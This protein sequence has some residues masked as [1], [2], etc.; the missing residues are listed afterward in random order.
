M[1]RKLVGRTPLV[2]PIAKGARD[3][4]CRQQNRRTVRRLQTQSAMAARVAEAIDQFFRGAVDG[5]ALRARIEQE[6]AR[7]AANH[8]AL[9]D[10]TLPEPGLYDEGV[11]IAQA[12]AVSKNRVMAELLYLIVRQVDPRAVIELGTNVA[13]AVDWASASDAT[14][15]QGG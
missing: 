14:P 5:D 6:R 9:V 2:G 4:F 12:C 13:C 8:E 7:M 10:G 1:L 11:S 3:L 15:I